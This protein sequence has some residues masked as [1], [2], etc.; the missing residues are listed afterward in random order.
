MPSAN[1]GGFFSPGVNR[2][3]K[4]TTDDTDGDFTTQF[5]VTDDTDEEGRGEKKNYGFPRVN[6]AYADR[7]RM[8]KERRGKEKRKRRTDGLGCL[9][10]LRVSRN[11][12]KRN[13]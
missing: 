5:P 6:R 8:K 7:T 4:G 9:R 13:H 11:E 12:P 3:E 10:S 1:A 2:L